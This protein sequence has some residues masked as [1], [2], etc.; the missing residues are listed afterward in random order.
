MLRKLFFTPTG[1][2][3]I[4]IRAREYLERLTLAVY[5]ALMLAK[6]IMIQT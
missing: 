3:R 4:D 6:G 1:P 2:E 5:I